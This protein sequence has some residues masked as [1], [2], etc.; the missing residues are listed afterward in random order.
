MDWPGA[1]ARLTADLAEIAV[2]RLIERHQADDFRTVSEQINGCAVT[3]MS[4]YPAEAHLAIGL[5][6]AATEYSPDLSWSWYALTKS[7]ELA[8]NPTLRHRALAARYEL[9]PRMNSCEMRA[10]EARLKSR[11]GHAFV[12]MPNDV[13]AMFSGTEFSLA[14]LNERF[15]WVRRDLPACGKSSYS[16]FV[17]ARSHAD[18]AALELAFAISSD[19]EVQNSSSDRANNARF[20]SNIDH[21]S[22]FNPLGADSFSR[23]LMQ[24]LYGGSHEARLAEHRPYLENERLRD[25]IQDEIA[26]LISRLPDHVSVSLKQYTI[27]LPMHTHYFVREFECRIGRHMMTFLP[28]SDQ[29]KANRNAGVDLTEGIISKQPAIV[30]SFMVVL[31]AVYSAVRVFMQTVGD[32]DGTDSQSVQLRSDALRM[33]FRRHISF[34]LAHELAHGYI[35]DGRTQ[36]VSENTIDCWAAWNV[37][38]AHGAKATL[39]VFS[40]L[41]AAIR[42]GRGEYWNIDKDNATTSHASRITEAA[43]HLG[44][45]L[46]EPEMTAAKSCAH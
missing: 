43:T 38:A 6:Q 24:A 11:T 9:I 36:L 35:A 23:I 34:L 13:E 45:F 5:V 19:L 7:A 33:E 25:L 20:C 1:R 3:A 46:A 30:V 40:N 10:A 44:R 32:R 16:N 28:K 4:Y 18:G 42:E 39:G 41:A 14:K 31:D 2:R 29:L 22:I 26:Y 17:T 27:V 8:T 15:A 12:E 37:A 21:Q